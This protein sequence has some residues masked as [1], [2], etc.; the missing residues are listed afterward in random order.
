MLSNP[1]RIQFI[2]CTRLERAARRGETL[3][4][5]LT[6]SLTWKQYTTATVHAI[7]S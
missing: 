3:Y 5:L 2:H 7:H 1:T 6:L 4:R